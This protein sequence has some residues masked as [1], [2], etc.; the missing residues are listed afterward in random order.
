MTVSVASSVVSA[1]SAVISAKLWNGRSVRSV[2][3]QRRRSAS[4]VSPGSRL[5]RSVHATS[6]PAPVMRAAV[7]RRVT[8]MPAGTVSVTVYAPDGTLP[9]LAT[10]IVNVAVAR[11]VHRAPDPS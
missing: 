11:R 2:I 8:T 4:L 7:A 9:W 1:L 10:V 5:G 6:L 3:A